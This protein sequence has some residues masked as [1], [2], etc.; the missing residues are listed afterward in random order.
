MIRQFWV[1]VAYLALASVCV[2]QGGAPS[3]TTQVPVLVELFT[4]EGCSTCPP[5][6]RFLEVLD[7]QPVSGL[8]IIVLSEHVTYWDHQGWKDPYSSSDLTERQSSYASRFRLNDVYTP[9]LVIDGRKQ[10]SGVS[11][12]E[13][14]AALKDALNYSRTDL[15]ITD[16][17]V[18]GGKVRLHVESALNLPDQARDA[19]LYVAVALNHAESSVSAGENAKKHLTHTSVV[20]KLVRVAKFKAGEKVARD[21]ECRVDAKDVANLRVVAF[22]QDPASGRVLGS[23]MKSVSH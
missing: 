5:A 19:D 2:A 21:V 13:A 6:D 15:R 4:S 10:M 17:A 11:F 12:K 18:D 7:T 3:A 9:Q 8:Q 14:E 22:L 23:T 16:V 1:M 20:R